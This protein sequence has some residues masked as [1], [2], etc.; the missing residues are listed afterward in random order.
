M[1][2]SIMYHAFGAV[3]YRYLHFQRVGGE[4]HFFLK[5][6]P[7]KRC[8]AACGSYDVTT[9]GINAARVL[10]SVPVGKKKTFLHL[11]LYRL[12][13]HNCGAIRQEPVGLADPR[14]RYTRQLARLIMELR[15]H[16]TIKAIAAYT[17]LSWDVVK[18]IE[19]N[20]LEKHYKQPS[21]KDVEYFAVDELHLGK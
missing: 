14:V 5:K 1:S 7:E 19:K 6:H 18:D 4:L 15:P 21:L 10:Q 11:T 2:T 16:M 8:C 9:R 17:G 12:D 3:N 20:W 13:C